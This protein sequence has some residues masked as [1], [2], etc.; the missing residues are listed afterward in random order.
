MEQLTGMVSV[1]SD[2]VI[3][4][5]LQTASDQHNDAEAQLLDLLIPPSLFA[6]KMIGLPV[7]TIT[8]KSTNME[9]VPLDP[10]QAARQAREPK[11]VDLINHIRTNP[12]YDGDKPPVCEMCDEELMGAW[13]TKRCMCRPCWEG[14]NAEDHD[15]QPVPGDD[16]DD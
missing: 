4:A 14:L 13:E 12:A 1:L 11:P 3:V 7:G 10:I 15:D 16:D 9:A 2:E 6:K 5:F 8:T